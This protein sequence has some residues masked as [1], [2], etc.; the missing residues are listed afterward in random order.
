MWSLV[1]LLSCLQVDTVTV[2]NEPVDLHIDNYEHMVLFV[3][4]LSSVRA[5]WTICACCLHLG[6]ARQA[7]LGCDPHYAI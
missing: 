5:C 4:C 3:C 6:G 1:I 2:D 7:C